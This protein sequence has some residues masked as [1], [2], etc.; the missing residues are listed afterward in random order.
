MKNNTFKYDNLTCPVC[1][2]HKIIKKRHHNK[3]Q[4]NI[5]GKTTEFK[6]LQYR[7]KKY[8]KNLEYV[9]IY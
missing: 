8:G 7:S 4:T 1:R 5:N 6:E 2:S 3:K 9:I